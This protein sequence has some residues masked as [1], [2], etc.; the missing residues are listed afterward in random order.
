VGLGYFGSIFAPT[1]VPPRKDG[2][3]R[4]DFEDLIGFFNR[5]NRSLA[6]APGALPLDPLFSWPIRAI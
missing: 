2:V 4:D 6:G 1:R 3:H 5:F